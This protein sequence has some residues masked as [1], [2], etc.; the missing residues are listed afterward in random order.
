VR[1]S[2]SWALAAL[3]GVL[4]VFSFPK[5]GHGAVA[6]VAL[7]PLLIS[8]SDRRGLAA[9]ARGYATGAIS[10]IGLL[11][12]TA[13][14][15]RQYGGLTLGV[16]VLIALLLAMAV[17]LFSALFAWMLA[18]WHRAWG[19]TALLLSPLA[20]VTIEILR[21]HTFFQFPWCLLGYSQHD[22]LPVVQIAAHAA[23]YGV[24]F[25][26]AL[27]SAV[28]AYAAVE[29]RRTRMTLAL[30]GLAVTLLAC[31]ALGFLR[32]RSHPSA[33]K[34]IRV[35]LIQASIPQDEK[36]SPAHAWRNIGLHEQLTRRAASG[37]ARLVVWPES[38]VPF[39][40]DWTPAVAQRLNDLS[41]EQSVWLLFGNDDIEN[42]EVL[43][44]VYVG[45]KMLDPQGRLALRYHKMHLVPFGEYVPLAAI[46]ERLGVE[47]LVEEVGAFMPG[48]EPRVG[49]L[50]G[51]RVATTIC[52]ETI[53]P[54]LVRRFTANGAELLVNVT[55]DGW[56]G[57][58]SAPYQHFAMAR[59]R[60]VEN[61]RYLL[62]A[63]N[64]GIS[65]IIDPYG[66]V[67]ART[68][69]FERTA[70]VGAADFS[71]E[72]TFYASHGD[73]FAWGCFIAAA[74]LTVMSLLRRKSAD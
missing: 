49:L 17:A 7:A 50:E 57:R 13:L 20:W 28:I 73:V 30:T 53:F 68:T 37:G 36:W 51:H 54:D 67:L 63:A 60:A 12:W 18:V 26:V 24:S 72:T 42:D 41:R 71:G 44:K 66:R 2:T 45:A 23:V 3:S 55:N 16:S 9:A 14:V 39:Y 61:G 35:G 52:Y 58:T 69:L 38:A 74:G 10:A 11:Y 46:L 15:T 43:G 64:T 19:A 56:Y 59:F 6:W 1:G 4:L 21:T 31:W 25:I 34:Q 33:P 70:L 62:R 65:A 40:Y 48:R 29:R 27:S 47:K 22:N 8:L 5:F 32:M